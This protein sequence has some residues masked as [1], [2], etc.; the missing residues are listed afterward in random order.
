MRLGILGRYDKQTLDFINEVGFESFGTAAT[1]KSAINP[2]MSDADIVTI[3]KELERRGIELS[4]IGYYR[5]H[6]SADREYGKSETEYFMKVLDLA[7]RMGVKLVGTFAGCNND[8]TIEENL[9]LFKEVFS[10]MVEK[11]E[12]LG[13]TIMIEGC[14]MFDYRRMKLGNIAYGPEIWR[15][16]FSLI[17]SDHLALEYDPSH[18]VGL[19]IDYIKPIHEFGK[20]IVHVHAKDAEIR[21]DSLADY[22]V[23]GKQVGDKMGYSNG[24]CFA[25]CPGWGDVDWAK[26]VTA[27][28]EQK[29]TG[30]IDIELEDEIMHFSPSLREG[31]RDYPDSG[32]DMSCVYRV[33]ELGYNALRP[34]IPKEK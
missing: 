20:K 30:N 11:A 26:V 1:P 32:E 24:Y 28:V 18:L 2:S 17:P 25:R 19:M 9:P 13:L 16:M 5:N 10:P 8:L 7:A 4:N 14:T 29:Y 12:K 33:L 23:Y 15:E 31:Y 6:L 21:G 34:L 22:G 3:L 27:L